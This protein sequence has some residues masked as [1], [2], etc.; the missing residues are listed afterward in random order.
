M[1]YS[2]LDATSVVFTISVINK[3]NSCENTRSAAFTM[4]AYTLDGILLKFETIELSA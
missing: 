4:I 3:S 1:D 2:W